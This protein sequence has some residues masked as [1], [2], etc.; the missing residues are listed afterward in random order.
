MINYAQGAATCQPLVDPM[1]RASLSSPPAANGNVLPPHGLC[2][3]LLTLNSPVQPGTQRSA[4]NLLQS[5][6]CSVQL[7]GEGARVGH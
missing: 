4:R 1:K 3:Q 7:D 2:N 5:E 6:P